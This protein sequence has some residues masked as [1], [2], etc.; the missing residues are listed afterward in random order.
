MNEVNLEEHRF[1]GAD[2][3]G[4]TVCGVMVWVKNYIQNLT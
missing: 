1:G 3:G 4:L 2:G